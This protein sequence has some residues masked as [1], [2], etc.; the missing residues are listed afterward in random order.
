MADYLK[1]EKGRQNWQARLDIPVKLRPSF[2]G[3]RVLVK[4]LGT[5]NKTL[6]K[7]RARLVVGRWKA[8]LRKAAGE[9][10]DAIMA[11]AKSWKAWLDETSIRMG[12][13]AGGPDD[14]SSLVL[15]SRAQEIENEQGYAAAK[16]FMDAAMGR[17]VPLQEHLDD[18]L[19]TLAVEPKTA[20]MK[21]SA[22]LEACKVWPA[23]S[24]IN[25]RAVQQWVELQARDL[26]PSSI[27]RRLAELRGYYGWLQ[28][29][30][31]APE[32]LAPFDK[33]V[34]PK[35]SRKAREDNQPRQH[36]EPADVVRLVQLAVD[37]GDQQLADFIDLAR[38]TGC[39]AEELASLKAENVDLDKATLTIVDAK[40]ASG[41]RTLPI[42]S[43]LM[44]VM[45]RLVAASTDGY[46]MTGL[47]FD[48]FKDRAGA[49]QRRFGRLKM[50]AGYGPE[51]VLHSIRR[52]F[53]TL[54]EQ[55]GVAEH[56]AADL[57]GHR[58]RGATLSFG[59]YSGGSSMDQRRAAVEKVTYP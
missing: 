27:G 49:V 41:R 45:Q 10:P 3:K 47:S 17:L 56:V 24:D 31:H 48:Q 30:G 35:A 38:W 28:R 42:H 18:Y 59:L 6:A 20:S 19:T 8:M 11:E 54:L 25:K 7:D 16:R 23:I 9:Q 46:V 12:D 36:F 32:D 57:L 52:T 15:T 50:K 34:M 1:R 29:H 37:K 5:S 43:K 40:S 44:P 33:L 21:R 55:A 53:A 58:H 39:R 2:D 26:M 14:D 51:L 4:S 22:I 13:E